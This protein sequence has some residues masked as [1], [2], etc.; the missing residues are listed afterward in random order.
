MWWILLAIAL[1][2]GTG[3]C[4]LNEPHAPFVITSPTAGQVI[5]RG[6]TV[7]VTWY[8]TPDTRYPI[9]GYAASRTPRTIAGLLHPDADRDERYLATIESDLLLS[10]LKYEWTV[11]EKIE[12]GQYRVGIGLYFHETSPVFDIV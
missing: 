2:L 1:N 11:D 10:D 12:P 5:Q 7:N 9:Y 8:L 4:Y 3:H 6:E